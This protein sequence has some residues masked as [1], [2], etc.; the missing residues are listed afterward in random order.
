MKWL[1]LFLMVPALVLGCRREKPETYTADQISGARFVIAAMV[2]S[3]ALR[4]WNQRGA[5]TV[6]QAFQ[7]LRFEDRQNACRAVDILRQ[8]DGLA[9]GF[10]I[11]E[12]GSG[13]R[14]GRYRQGR[15]Y[16]KGG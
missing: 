1:A 12:E 6:G 15:L 10:A 16:M 13:K 2:E 14:V 7:D 3:G 5:V 9:A 4:D 11:R 8:T